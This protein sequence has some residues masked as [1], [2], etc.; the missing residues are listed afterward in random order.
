[1]PNRK[2]S[3][4][5]D[6]I[7]ILWY[8]SDY[9]GLLPQP[10]GA[11]P[12]GVKHPKGTFNNKN[13]K[14][15]AA[16]SNITDCHLIVEVDSSDTHYDHLI[17]NGFSIATLHVDPEFKFSEDAMIDNDMS[18]EWVAAQQ[19]VPEIERT[20]GTVEDRCGC[21]CHISPFQAIP[22]MMIEASAKRVV[23]CLNVFPQ[24]GGISEHWSPRA[25]VTGR[26]LDCKTS[27]IC[28]FGSFVQASHEPSP[29]D[30]LATR[31]LDGIHLDDNDDKLA[32]GHKTA[33]LASG[34]EITCPKIAPVPI[35]QEVALKP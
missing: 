13:R 7:S 14:E 3:D 28:S 33:H 11:F 9:D 25:I 4:V 35:T 8:D 15:P 29:S 24:K 12:E 26:P 2:E 17:K 31:S 1:M 32:G 30:A 6:K 22:K 16:L 18:V 20:I 5:S 34:E 10:F 21:A 19:H 27:C 23:K